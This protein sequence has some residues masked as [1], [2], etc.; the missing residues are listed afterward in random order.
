MQTT[1]A[2]YKT[3]IASTPHWFETKITID[4]NEITET[5][6]FSLNRSKPGISEDYPTIGGALSASLT[7]TIEEVNFTIPTMAE[8]KVYVRACN[9]T[10][11]S[12]WL[13]KGTYYI[14]TRADAETGRTRITAYDAMLKTEKYYPETTH[15]WGY[16]D[17]SVL[18]EIATDIG[19]TVDSKTYEIVT[20][21]MEIP[22]PSNLTE[23]EVLQNIAC[24]YAGNFVI[25]DDNTLL[26]VPL[27]GTDLDNITAD[28]LADDSDGTTALVF[29]NEGWYIIV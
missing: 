2:L 24:A 18:E 4:G 28:Y 20:A 15:D 12:E 10:S 25:T 16:P 13:A 5:G 19:V 27:Y 29:G 3:I 6:L 21:A 1:S 23:R 9:E 17:I 14:D 8:I 7:L 26:L 22:L 11:Q